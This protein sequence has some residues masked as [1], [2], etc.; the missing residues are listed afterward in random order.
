MS[1]NLKSI[2][3]PVLIAIAVSF[4]TNAFLGNKTEASVWKKTSVEAIYEVGYLRTMDK[5]ASIVIQK[6]I[7]ELEALKN[8]DVNSILL[9]YKNKN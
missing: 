3:V 9:R 4:L 2:L 1:I 5:N 7:N 6:M 8:D